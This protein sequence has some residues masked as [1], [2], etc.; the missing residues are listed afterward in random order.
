MTRCSEIACASPGP[1]SDAKLRRQQLTLPSQETFVVGQMHFSVK[2]KPKTVNAASPSVGDVV[3]VKLS[4]NVSGS[5]GSRL[6]QVAFEERV[7]E[8]SIVEIALQ[9][10]FSRTTDTTVGKYLREHGASLRRPGQ[11][12]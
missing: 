10:L 8:S 9:M 5:V 2:A 6:R 12:S 7:S 4:V 3:P 1:R 11:I